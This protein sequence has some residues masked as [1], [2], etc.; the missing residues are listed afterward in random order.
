MPNEQSMVWN[1]M[2]NSMEWK[3]YFGMEYGNSQ[4]WSGMEDF[5]NGME[6]HLPYF[7][8][9]SILSFFADNK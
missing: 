1:G 5:Q 7:H 6:E 4:V 3:A 2:E 8:T 9:N